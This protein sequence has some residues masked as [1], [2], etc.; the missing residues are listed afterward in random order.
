MESLTVEEFYK[1]HKRELKLEQ[2]SAAIDSPMDIT[3]SDI[4][5]PAL[6]FTGF[7]DYFLSERIQIVGQTE[8]AYLSTLDEGTQ[9]AALERLFNFTFPCVILTKGLTPPPAMLRF[10]KARGIPVLGTTI[11]TT[12]FIHR[13]TAYLDRAFAP[14]TTIHGSLVD[15]YGVGL[16]FTGRSAIGKSECALDLVERGHRLV[17]D[18]VVTVVRRQG[19]ILIGSG[20][21]VLR[22][23]MEI[24]GLGIID[25]QSI[26]GI[27]SIRFQKRVEL[28]VN[29]QEWRDDGEY[30]RT[31]LDQKTTTILGVKIPLVQIPLF[32][33]KN[34]TVIAEVVALNYLVKVYSHDPAKRFNKALLDLMRKKTADIH[35]A[36]GRDE[37]ERDR[38]IN[39]EDDIE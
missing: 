23:H 10:S 33:G 14:Q 29:L 12:P 13:L 7:T 2:L 28:E 31:G 25:V 15:V 17:A 30:E 8:M 36:L 21:P 16:L 37:E 4:N 9:A 35:Y 34:I 32:P 24:R 26:F 39:I 18:D 27:R 1:Q 19:E 5:R 11:S 3:V 38:T 22:H 6:L 20:N